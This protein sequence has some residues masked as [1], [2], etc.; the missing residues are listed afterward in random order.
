MEN[1]SG[2]SSMLVRPAVRWLSQRTSRRSIIATVSKLSLASVGVAASYPGIQI[3]SGGKVAGETFSGACSEACIW[4]GL[5]GIRCDV[6]YGI[7]PT[8][9]PSELAQSTNSW[10]ACCGQCCGWRVYYDCCGSGKCD[11]HAHGCDW[12]CPQDNWC[13][14]IG[15]Y[16]C[17]IS[18]WTSR[19][20]GGC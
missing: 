9:C 18:V 17:T 1:D 12:G 6:C 19:C 5:C 2:L 4:C 13:L 7:G 20:A 10:G 14:G 16:V 15:P 8:Q 11:P 3:V